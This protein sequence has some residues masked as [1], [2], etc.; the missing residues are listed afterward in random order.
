[1]EISSKKPG[2]LTAP[3]CAAVLLSLLPTLAHGQDSATLNRYSPGATPSDD[4]A[5]SRPGE[6]SHLRWG[7]QLHMDYAHDPLVFQVTGGDEFGIVENQLTLALGASFDVY[8]RVA[9]YLGVPVVAVMNGDGSSTLQAAGLAASAGGG[10]VGDL[11]LGARARILGE[12]EDT[13]A[14]GAQFTLTLPTGGGELRGE[15]FLSV[16]PELLLELRLPLGMRVT[17]NVGVRVREDQN[18]AD[19]NLTFQDELTLGLGFAA[20]IWQDG[21]THLDAHAQLLASTAL[22]DAMSQT[23]TPAELLVG[24][25][26]HHES[27]VSTGLLAGPGLTTGL[28]TPQV[29]VVAYVGYQPPAEQPVAGPGDRDGDGLLDTEDDCPDDPEDPDQ[30]AD[31]DGCPDPDN[32]EDGVL[33]VDDQCPLE[34][35]DADGDRDEDGCP[36]PDRDGDGLADDV[37]QCPDD[38]EDMDEFEDDDGCPDPDNDGDGVLDL[39]DRCAMEPGPAGN[40][41]CPDPDRDGD[42]V[43]DR[44]DNCPDEHGPPVNQGC[45]EEQQ[46]RIQDGRLEILDVVHFRTNRDVIQRRSYGLLDNVGQVLNS[47]PEI[48]RIRVEGH[49]D[50]RGRRRHNVTLSQRRAEAVVAYLTEHADVDA[51]RLEA[52]GFGP[53][54]PVVPNA[55]SREDHARNRR[56]EFNILTGGEGIDAQNSGPTSDTVQE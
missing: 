52:R 4:F 49:T 11:S 28:G 42:T 12:A 3:L 2:L 51:A 9:V 35:E 45:A 56:V 37:D 39:Q 32:D 27:G 33:D 8:D 53:D 43:V 14:L 22:R 18:D 46:V 48:E 19:S 40:G 23:S 16:H 20:P 36:D 47:H 6:I 15:D 31:E 55:A 26:L 34:P 54:Q 21:S 5:I 13:F 24:A 1:M 29:R 25:K 7:Y 30:F 38:P 41:G 44:L 10:G 50:S 17:A